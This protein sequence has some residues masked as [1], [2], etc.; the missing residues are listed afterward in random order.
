L[1]DKMV[2]NEE[3][4]RRSFFIDTLN[5]NVDNETLSDADFRKFVKNSMTLFD[6]PNKESHL[7]VGPY[8]SGGERR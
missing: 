7:P 2:S 4:T 5:A 3:K 6:F 1:K 8:G